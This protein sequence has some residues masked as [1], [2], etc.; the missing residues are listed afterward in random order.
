MLLQMVLFHFLWLSRSHC[1]YIYHIFF[2]PLSLSEHLG[3]FHVLAVVNRAAVNVGV[4]V[5]FEL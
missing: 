4:Y 2:I 1:V 3:C 5:F